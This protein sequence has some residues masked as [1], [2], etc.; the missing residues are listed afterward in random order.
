MQMRLHV[1]AADDNDANVPL[2]ALFDGR[3]H[4]PPAKVISSPFCIG[5]PVL[6]FFIPSNPPVFLSDSSP[7]GG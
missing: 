6:L 3:H 7:C 2:T 4:Q 1:V 5:P